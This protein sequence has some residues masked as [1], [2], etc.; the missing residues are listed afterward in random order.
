MSTNKNSALAFVMGAALGGAVALLL[1][2]DKGEV[3]RQ[4]IRT[5]SARIVSRGTAAV[6]HA[7]TSVEDAG[8]AIGNAT[9]QQ[10]GAVSDAFAAAKE[11]YVREK[12]R[13]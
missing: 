12:N 4:R 1:A 5:G 8:H 9:R 6:D 13:V 11:T 3:T 7:K 2:P 10:A